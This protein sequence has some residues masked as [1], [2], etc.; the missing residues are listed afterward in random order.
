MSSYDE[1]FSGGGRQELTRVSQFGSKWG[2]YS[3]VYALAQSDIRRFEDITKLKMHECLLFLT[4]EKEKNE[5]EASQIKN[6]FNARN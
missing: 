1:L 2:W 4:F 6:K 5:I 3:S